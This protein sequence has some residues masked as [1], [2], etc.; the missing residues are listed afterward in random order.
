MADETLVVGVLAD[1]GLKGLDARAVFASLLL[2]L[3]R[4][5]LGLEV[6]KNHV[7]AGLGEH[8]DRRG[9]DAARAAGDERRFACERNHD[10]P[11]WNAIGNLKL[12]LL[13]LVSNHIAC[14]CGS[15]NKVAEQS[16]GECVSEHALGMPLHT[17]D[18][19]GVARPLDALDGPVRGTRSNAQILA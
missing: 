5:I 6:T 8:F 1:V 3:N 18:P 15:A 4:S 17:G 19:V 16:L 11:D 13:S 12:V 14:A 7:G 9:T 2:N 10:T